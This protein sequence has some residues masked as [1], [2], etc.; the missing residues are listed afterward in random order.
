MAKVTEVYLL[1][2]PLNKNYKETIK[3]SN[4]TNQHNYFSSKIK[5]SYI[6]FSMQ[7]RERQ[8]RIPDYIEDIFDCNYLMYRNENGRWFYCF[9]TSYEYVNDGLTLISYTFD[10]M[11]TYMFDYTLKPCLVER[12]HVNDDSVGANTV[13]EGLN[14]GELR[15]D[16]KVI[17][18][19]LT[20][21]VYILGSK[22][23]IDENN[24]VTELYG[25]FRNNIPSYIFLIKFEKFEYMEMKDYID[26]LEQH[27]ENSILFISAIPR[28]A[29]STSNIEGRRVYESSTIP[30]KEI[31]V[32]I[33]LTKIGNYTPKNNKLFVYPYNSI[34][35]SNNCGRENILK[36]E[37]FA[38]NTPKFFVKTF[39]SVQPSVKLIPA[40]YKGIFKNYEESIEFNNFPQVEF[41]TDG[42]K[43][44][45]NSAMVGVFS[46]I[47]N[48][49]ISAYSGN[50]PATLISG[51]NTLASLNAY[52][53]KS[54]NL[55]GTGVDGQLS[56]LDKQ[57]FKVYQQHIKYEYCVIIDNYFSKYGYRVDRVKVPNTVGRQNFNYVKTKDCL[58]VGS[59]PSTDLEEIENIFNNG[60]TF[61]HNT[62]NFG[63]YNVDNPII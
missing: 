11:Q 7:R 46:N 45:L 54:D 30:S 21:L 1:D 51:A 48:T 25:T 3:F 13:D 27:K 62:E 37:D 41:T 39:I 59:I 43:N 56:L 31:T 44:Y 18:T 52:S 58:C 9:I 22:Y 19:G 49:G 2:T 50:Y 36:I 8:I 38:N 10:V 20:D 17:D 47:V 6:N 34:S 32:N 61:F 23:Y 15:R 42:Y 55:K 33:D 40:Y 14:I 63:N 12:E 24:N 57:D 60:I 26:K 53:M 4:K 16:L 28:F 35:V 29:L 5:H